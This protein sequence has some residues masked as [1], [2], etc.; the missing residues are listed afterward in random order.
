MISIS[1]MTD[2]ALNRI[3]I[4]KSKTGKI[5]AKPLQNSAKL[6]ETMAKKQTVFRVSTSG[7]IP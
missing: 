6:D 2:P 1:T 3:L 5:L 7:E 4:A